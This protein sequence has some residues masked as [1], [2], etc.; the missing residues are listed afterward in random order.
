MAPPTCPFVQR[1]TATLPS[2]LWAPRKQVRPPRR[3]L[4]LAVLAVRMG[5]RVVV[6]VAASVARDGEVG[7][8]CVWVF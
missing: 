6:V 5:R 1:C 4:R 8:R 3:G 7:R 2:P